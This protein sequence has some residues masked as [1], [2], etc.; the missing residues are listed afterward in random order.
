GRSLY[1]D[2][3]TEDITER[4]RA[5]AALAESEERFRQIAE[6][7]RD[8]FW[9]ADLRQPK[10]FYISPAYEEVWGRSRQSLY[11]NPLSFLDAV[12]PE[13]REEV[14]DALARQFEGERVAKEYRILRP[15][16]SQRWILDR[17]FPICDPQ[18]RVACVTGIAE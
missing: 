1:Y 10:T 15:D 2:G 14:R 6:T 12:H 11:D 18:G 4:K 9:M 13:D 8:V 3:I 5:Q 7:I 16:G 17:G